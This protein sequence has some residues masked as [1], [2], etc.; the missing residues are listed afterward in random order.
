MRSP[1]KPGP[2][3]ILFRRSPAV[4]LALAISL[5]GTSPASAYQAPGRTELASL[6]S[7]GSQVDSAFFGAGAWGPDMT[8]DGRHVAFSF[9]GWLTPDAGA[10]DDVYLRD[11]ETGSVELISKANNGQPGNFYDQTPATSDD[12]RYVAFESLSTNLGPGDNDQI[13]DIYLRDREAGIT[14]LVSKSAAGVKGTANSTW[15]SISADGRYVAFASISSNLVPNDVNP[16]GDVFVKDRQTGAVELISVS[17]DEAAA[18][19]D[20]YQ[21]SMSADG[22]Y[23]A[24]TSTAS[25]LVQGDLNDAVDVFLRDR[26]AGTT[27]IISVSSDETPSYG[28]TYNY[29]FYGSYLPSISADGNQVGFTSYATNL[30]PS[31]TNVSVDVFVRDR[32]AGTTER[33]TVSSQGTESHPRVRTSYAGCNCTYIPFSVS[34]DNFWSVLSPDGRYVSFLSE[35]DDLVPGDTNN[36]LYDTFV[37]DRLTGETELVSLASD[38]S[39]PARGTSNYRPSISGGGRHVAFVHGGDAK[40]GPPG[41]I[42]YNHVYVRDRGP[43][44]GTGGVEAAVDGDSINVAGW[45]S[46]EGTVVSHADDPIDGNGFWR[47]LGAELT[48]ASLVYRP[49]QEDLLLRMR[50]EDLKPATVPQ[51][52]NYGIWYYTGEEFHNVSCHSGS[53]T[54]APGYTVG[55]TGD[56]IWIRLPVAAGGT[57]IDRIKVFAGQRNPATGLYASLDEV[58][59]PDATV[60]ATTV[61]LGL[62]PVGTA[63]ADV[64]F[65]TPAE[66]SNGRFTGTLDAGGLSGEYDV[67]ARSC[68]GSACGSERASVSL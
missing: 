28:H 33:V 46:L 6:R 40:L 27:E 16:L 13:W 64:E 50:I 41:T 14:E 51:A 15:P 63:E 65:S 7:D 35:S 22:R 10:L 12:A 34:A 26:V 21:P 57:R 8:P 39:Q 20:S 9:D 47:N 18:I 30:V 25:N 24:F 56:E 19:G 2:A 55:T 42:A 45:A 11:R 4:T 49:E 43:Q 53:C 31:D 68:L 48:G 37:H 38:G 36:T 61:S 67:W 29:Y 52:V 23:V 32:A 3:T 5:L 58:A 17:T 59:L 1:D 62:A 54:G 66:L 44:A 60:P